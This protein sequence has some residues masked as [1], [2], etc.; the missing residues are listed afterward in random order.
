MGYGRGGGVT[1]EIGVGVCEDDE[2]YSLQQHSPIGCRVSAGKS[3]VVCEETTWFEE[4][5]INHLQI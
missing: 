1:A 3:H 5:D 4:S 2:L